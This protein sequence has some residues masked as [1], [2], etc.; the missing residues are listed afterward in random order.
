MGVSGQVWRRASTLSAVLLL[1]VGAAGCR[2]EEP[3]ASPTG[4][5]DAGGANAA[6]SDTGGASA[7]ASDAGGETSASAESP[8]PAPKPKAPTL[9]EL[10]NAE[11]MMPAGC[12]DYMYFDGDYD[13]PDYTAEPVQFTD[14]EA[15]GS[16]PASSFTIGDVAV[17]LEAED[18]PATVVQISCF[19]GGSYQY[20][21]LAAYDA[22]LELVGYVD[23]LADDYPRGWHSE[24]PHF[25]DVAIDGTTL[26]YTH[27]G[28]ALFGDGPATAAPKSGTATMSWTHGEKGFQLTDTVL[29]TPEGPV[30]PVKKED[31]QPFVDLLAAENF[32][33]AESYWASPELVPDY[34]PGQTDFSTMEAPLQFGIGDL[35]PPGTVVDSCEIIGGGTFGPDYGYGEW[36]EGPY[37]MKAGGQ[38]P[39]PSMVKSNPDAEDAANTHPGDTVCLLRNDQSPPGGP[40][41]YNQNGF[42]LILAGTED[43]SVKVRVLGTSIWGAEI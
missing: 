35:V 30:R 18:G 10:K 14:G 37:F 32:E 5:S 24:K 16:A 21:A 7:A 31:V 34:A 33:G 8:S 25:S 27:E 26:T 1:A 39:I 36:Y 22:D 3:A 23:S 40:E 13:G 17:P 6:A 42:H 12:A 15:P 28:I 19:G 38:I 4:A 20:P 9:E 29:N 2:S 11:L 41:S 43:G